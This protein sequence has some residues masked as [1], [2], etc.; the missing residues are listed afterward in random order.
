MSWSRQ[1]GEQAMAE[2]AGEGINRLR[3]RLAAGDPQPPAVA[4]TFD[5]HFEP[6][7]RFPWMFELF[8]DLDKVAASMPRAWDPNPRRFAAGPAGLP[9]SI[10]PGNGT[11]DHGK[12]LALEQDFDDQSGFNSIS[13]TTF[14]T[15]MTVSNAEPTRFIVPSETKPDMWETMQLEK[16]IWHDRLNVMRRSAPEVEKTVAAQI[17]L[18][19]QTKRQ[20]AGANSVSVG[21]LYTLR[22]Q[23]TEFADRLGGGTPV[24]KI[25]GQ[26]LIDYRTHLLQQV[27][28]KKLA[29]T[30]ASDR[31]S[32]V[33]SFIR[34]L[35]QTEA[36]ADLPRV[37]HSRSK[38]LEIGKSSRR[39]T[40]FS[41]SEIAVLLGRASERTR[42][43]IL[44]TLN[45]AMTQ[46]DMAD[47]TFD[48]IDWEQGRIIRK[49]SKTRNSESVPTVSYKLWPETK[50]LLLKQ[51]SKKSTGR[52]LL[53]ARGE[54][55]WQEQLTAEG[56]YRKTDNLRN[57]FDRL[58]RKTHI[59]KP[60]TSLKKT[61]ASLL[62][63]SQQFN[64][65]VGLFLG[66]APRDVSQR[67]YAADPQLL[68]D[69][70]I[71]WLHDHY[72]QHQCSVA[73]SSE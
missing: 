44:L 35:W 49:R 43:Y 13:P 41:E 25:S 51:R 72:A 65:V 8:R 31:L 59:D 55:L 71:A 26:V 27:A 64:S 14:A 30:T 45:T 28:D 20:E 21:R 46:K 54:P 69:S 40:T 38:S 19:L 29:K 66:H 9:V 47:L 12:S 56:R 5:G 22:H 11:A 10:L 70:A 52:V 42:L 17:E 7:I 62:R 57:A 6:K 60:F 33:K 58:R 53:N 50:D 4:D 39:I 67:Y 36:I 15:R 68:L 73:R 2:I 63:E 61:S 48:E 3:A 32:S 1:H 34:W 23:L 16:E 18:Y 37:L 24:D